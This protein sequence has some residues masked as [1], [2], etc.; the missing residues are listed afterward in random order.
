MAPGKTTPHELYSVV[1][2]DRGWEVLDVFGHAVQ[3]LIAPNGAME[4]PCLL[5]GTIPPGVWI[6]LHSH[7]DPESFY[8]LSGQAGVLLEAPDGLNWSDASS[9][10]FVQIPSGAKHAFRN[11]LLEPVV[12]LV[13][14]TARL[15]H[16]FA[17]IGSRY[18]PGAPQRPTPADLER[19]AAAAA[20]YQCW[21]GGAEEN[22]A[23]G[24]L[25]P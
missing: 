23:A 10:D 9:G 1:E 22:A 11:I 17:E 13:L 5:K 25:M 4:S 7:A 6:P 14:T 19:F 20:T 16:F 8:V 12:F 24:V 3:F 2:H 21:L 18:V 15:G